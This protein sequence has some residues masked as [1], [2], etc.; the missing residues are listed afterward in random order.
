MAI[1]TAAL[2]AL[3]AAS[4]NFQLPV[5]AGDRDAGLAADGGTAVLAEAPAN[6]MSRFAV[7][8]R[9]GR[10][11]ERVIALR[12]DFGYDAVSPDGSTL[13]VIRYLSRD[14]RRYA[15]QALKA[16]D[17]TPRLQTVVEKGEPGERMSG[18]PVSRTTGRRGNWVYTLYDGAGGEPFIHALDTEATYTVCVDLGPLAGRRDIATLKLW[19]GDDDRTI[20]VATKNGTPILRVDTE[21]FAVRAAEHPASAAARPREPARTESEAASSPPWLLLGALATTAAIAAAGIRKTHRR[22]PQDL[23]H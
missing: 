19:S 22:E 3:A 9:A 18:L 1:G 15:V 11:L 7:V 21:S 13:F 20:T 8:D 5:V 6:G 23:S 12:G 10:R 16:D 17:P 4:G 14:H 2:V